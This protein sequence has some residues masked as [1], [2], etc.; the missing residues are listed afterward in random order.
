VGRRGRVT[1]FYW[2]FIR[3]YS[4]ESQPKNITNKLNNIVEIS[5]KYSQ[6]KLNVKLYS[7]LYDKELYYIAYNHLKN[8]NTISALEYNTT[9]EGISDDWINET[10]KSLKNESFQFK[11]TKK[12]RIFK[13]KSFCI[14]PIAS[15]KDKI[16]QEAI[17]II[18]EIVFD[19]LFSKD[20]HGF[21]KQKSCHSALHQIKKEFQITQW[22]INCDIAKVFDSI[23]HS[24]LI[25]LLKKRI[26]DNRMLNL[27]QKYL[28]SG[29]WFNLC[30]ISYNLTDI[31]Q[32]G[33]L[34][35]LLSNIILNE[36]DNYLV[37]QKN[38]N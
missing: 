37:L 2:L 26:S 28:K 17:R 1:G 33:I 13:K 22:I 38:N 6:N 12:I 5:N 36:L 23:E 21:Q 31:P 18:L 20:N 35:P 8:K 16:V 10:I 25:N 7:L 30:N 15:F 4:V 3:S 27:I 19:P 32:D 11:P 14:L 9:F 24:I 29:Y 34:S